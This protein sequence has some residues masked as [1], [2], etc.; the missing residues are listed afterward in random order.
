[1]SIKEKI[2]K[3]KWN[4]IITIIYAIIT[5]V[6]TVVFHE[7]W[8]DEAQAWL[9]AR[10]IDII[11]I[12]KQMSYEGHPPL[13]YL[14]LA[15]FAKMGFPYITESIISWGIMVFTSW[16]LLKK[17]PF[18]KGIQIL[19]LLSEPFIYL[20]PTISRS[21]CL[22]PLAIILIAIYYPVRKEK[23]IQYAS[24]ILLLAY[25]HVIMLALVGM[26]YFFFFT[27]QIFFTKK[28]KQDIKKLIIAV[29]IGAIGLL[30]LVFMLMGSTDK[31]GF[32]S[33]ENFND[34][35][36]IKAKVVINVVETQICGTIAGNAVFKVVF[37]IWCLI[38]TLLGIKKS[39]KSLITAVVS[40]IWQMYIYLFIYISSEQR[41]N[42]IILI[43]FLIAWINIKENKKIN[44]K[45][46]KNIVFCGA[47]A[48]LILNV[49][50]GA[51]K[52]IQDYKTVYSAAKVTA[53]YIEEN[54]ENDAVF[55]CTDGPISSAIIPYIKNKKFWNPSAEE[56]FTYVTLNE[57]SNIKMSGEEII[58]KAK[59][60][61]KDR[62]KVYIL[63]CNK[64][65]QDKSLILLYKSEKNSIRIE[66]NYIIYEMNI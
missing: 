6:V 27:E 54:I 28:S 41:T 5:F 50:L 48:L 53:D 34:F 45:I 35:N 40:I 10:D 14:I 38:L 21:Y 52:I 64:K 51:Q 9:I 25:T 33:I 42:T 16:L 11:G 66:E 12:I 24:S 13:W 49:I 63:D 15:P 55:V 37:W 30:C 36:I 17:S 22:I 58:K 59:E 20:Y 1:M 3:D 2:K 44:N 31:N 8:R 57:K 46:L 23:Q 65:I 32:I 39:P 60:R 18:K 19:I 29:S 56:Y 47:I 26:L 7:K 43:G 61:F 4:I 62:E